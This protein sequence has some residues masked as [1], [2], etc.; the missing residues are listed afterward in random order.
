[1]ETWQLVIA[2]IFV[3]WA[4]V[5]D[6]Q[7]REISN[8][9]TGGFLLLGI[10]LSIYNHTLLFMIISVVVTTA[11]ALLLFKMGM[12]G[13]G[14][15]KLFIALAAFTGI[16]WTFSIFFYSLIVSLPLFAFY[17]IKERTRKP[18]VP[19]AIAILGGLA[20]ENISPLL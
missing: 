3:V 17:M 11:I 13:G 2:Y 6:I 18:C 10:A 12:F 8:V 15:L 5:T 16:E 14:D 7:K 9:L 20:W 19:Y 4:V 1:M